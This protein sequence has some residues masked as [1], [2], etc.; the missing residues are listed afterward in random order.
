MIH[1]FLALSIFLVVVCCRLGIDIPNPLIVSKDL[2]T[3][4]KKS[5]I[6]F[7]TVRAY[8]SY[9][10]ID[11]N[12]ITNIKNA[13]KS[14]IN[15]VDIYIFPCC[16]CGNPRKQV[17]DTLANL[18]GIDFDIVW[19]D[20]E[21]YAWSKDKAQ[22]RAF[23]T[24]MLDEVVKHGRKLGVYTNWREWDL[25]VGRDWDGASKYLLWYPYWNKDPSF[26]DFQKFGGWTTPYRKQIAC[27]TFYCSEKFLVDYQP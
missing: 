8:R 27:D 7:L 12:G 15:D 22:N 20:V 26:K 25:V 13:K 23:I 6:D 9:G 24:E 4:I 17:T 1:K 14:G 2:W 18:K 5:N 11:P 19:V 16:T 21:E 3:C 10:S